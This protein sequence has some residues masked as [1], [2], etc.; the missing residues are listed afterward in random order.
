MR[1]LSFGQ[2]LLSAFALLLIILITVY[3]VINDRRLS[4][5]TQDYL[6][7]MKQ[8]VVRQSTTSIA[9]WLNTRLDITQGVADQLKGVTTDD[10]AQRLFMTAT[11]GGGFK[12]V[13]VGTGSGK[14]LME[15]AEAASTLPAGYDPRSRPWYKL[16]MSKQAAS[17]T[18]PYKDASTGNM[19]ISSLAPVSTGTYQGVVAGDITLD[20]VNQVL[21]DITMG[22]SGYAMLVSASGT[23]LFDPDKALIGKN[24]QTLLK[25]DANLDGET[26]TYQIDGTPWLV[27]FNKITAARG[28]D[29]YLGIFVDRDKIMAPVNQARW[30][31]LII[32]VV[33]LLVAL[34]ILQIG[35]KVLMR[36]V[37]SLRDA[38]RDIA[39]GDADLTKTLSVEGSDEFAQLAGDF[40]R[41]VANIRG[42][43][44]EAQE[45]GGELRGHV[46]SLKETSKI[47][48]DSVETQQH[49]I[50][51]VATAINEMS[52]AA[53][54]IAQS[55]QQTADSANAADKDANA[56]LNTV[57]ASR[58]AV[59]RLAHEVGQAAEVIDRLGNDV[60]SI[61]SVLEVIEGIAEQTN[62]LALNAAIEAARAGEAGR[63][64]AVVADE[65]R[66]LAKRT[67]DSTEEI[68]GMI[69]RLQK[70][71]HDAVQ[72][73][74]ASRA[75]SNVSMEKAQDAM[76]ALKR[77]AESINAIS[78]M[79]SQIATA[80]EEQTSV[81]EELNSSITRIADQG[82]LAAKAATEND[83]Y[84]SK[85]EEVG[86]AL[87][88]KVARFRV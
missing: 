24:I 35:L 65:V 69:E 79:T 76:D 42:V 70:G 8:E 32:A 50:D 29:W 82:Q 15:S 4:S 66:N 49:E 46:H 85:I 37:Y 71:A 74:Q 25:A 40:N 77:I 26:H 6:N 10:Q 3:V 20:Q 44:S 30:T 80:S 63:G 31:G 83:S 47:S 36:P 86:N 45:S 33:G 14:M 18:E 1:Q 34:I 51:M 58:D 16:G 9:Q 28:V 27:S 56:S 68:N 52:A 87:H 78:N 41:F 22:G 62:L 57:Q 5:T 17:Y 12:D 21:S 7:A 60:A 55:A 2:K 48:R 75:V 59:E 13:Y 73:M 39:S 64:F 43:V 11:T 23:I 88:D 67:Q 53:N 84:S 38:M 61:T 19:I 54:E 81:T 72:G